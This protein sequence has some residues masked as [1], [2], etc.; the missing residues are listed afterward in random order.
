MYVEATLE[1]LALAALPEAPC[2]AD[3]DRDGVVAVTDLLA[4]L[5]AWG[6]CASCAA[7]VT[8]DGVV[9]VADLLDVLA[10]WGTCG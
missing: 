5:A 3:V 9:D 4:V 10:S 6:A 8:G 1:L 2:P 7:D